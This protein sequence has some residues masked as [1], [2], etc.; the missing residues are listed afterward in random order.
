MKAKQEQADI[1][2]INKAKED[3]QRSES[4]TVN[5]TDM[6]KDTAYHGPLKVSAQD[7]AIRSVI[8][9]IAQYRRAGEG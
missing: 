1:E 8:K 9:R 6:F 3:R 5:I 4:E 7:Q 2:A